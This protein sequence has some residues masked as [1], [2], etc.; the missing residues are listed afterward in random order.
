MSAQFGS[1]NFD[2]ADQITPVQLNK[3]ARILDPYG[4]DCHGKHEASG[5]R[6]LFR[7]FHTTRESRGEEQPRVGRTGFILMWDG[8][9]DNRLELIRQL[10]GVPAPDES[11]LAIVC[12]SY[13]HWGTGCFARIIGDWAI[14]IWEPR[15]RRVILARDPIGTRHL[16]YTVDGR[17]LVW[18]TLIDAV[19]ATVIQKPELDEEYIAGWLVFSPSVRLSPYRGIQPVPPSCY[20]SV[21]NGKA[22][23][24]KYWDFDPAKKTRFAHDRD[25][26]EQFRELFSQ[27]VRRRLRSDTAILAELSGGMDSTSIVCMSDMILAKGEGETP[28]LD[29]VSFYDDSEPNWNER[30]YF[31][32]VEKKRGR[33]GCHIDV[34]GQSIFNLD[35]TGAHFSGLPGGYCPPTV[36]SEQFATLVARQGN[37]VLL[38]GV[39]GDETTGGVPSATPE[40]ADLL[41]SRRFRALAHKLKLWAINKR[42]PW[43]HLFWEALHGFLPPAL[44][45]LPKY[46]RPGSWLQRDF[47]QSNKH[48]LAGYESRWLFFGPD[49]T[50]QINIDTL[51]GLRGQLASISLPNPPY[52]KRYPYLDRDFLEFVFSV[53]RE[54]MVRPGQRRSLMRRALDGVV[55]DAILRR[56]RKAFVSRNPLIEFKRHSAYVVSLTQHLVAE[57]LGVADSSGVMKAIEDACQGKEIPLAHLLRVFVLESWLRSAAQSKYI[58][59]DYIPRR[60][61]VIGMQRS[62]PQVNASLAGSS[63]NS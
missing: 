4:P 14:S 26:E 58:K 50:F 2:G 38:S 45:G 51:N 34:S 18:S 33:T 23:V 61:P 62:H 40:L 22:T 6:M 47:I 12:E 42:K 19:L 10:G 53:P 56:R 7:G 27:A 5:L 24:K 46:R 49:P 31:A 39:G 15:E 32:E 1:W 48:A 3:V 44:V 35:F 54:Q 8:R 59:W 63:S 21:Q 25:Y 28:R 52:E 11:D 57:S 16:Y 37:R 9:L 20:V 29:T 30:E 17:A 36:M 43:F 55:P 13:E 41:A 60:S